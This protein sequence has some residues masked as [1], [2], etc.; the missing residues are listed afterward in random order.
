[1][2]E[3]E[4]MRFVD[5]WTFE[6]SRVFPHPLERVWRAITD[7]N[8]I[9]VWFE[10]N[11]KFDLRLGGAYSFGGEDSTMRGV[12][13]ALDPPRFIRFSDPPSG[14]DSYFQFT[15]E[16]VDGGTRV[17]FTHGGTPGF[18]EGWPPPGLFAGWH[19]ALNNLA[20]LLEA[21]GRRLGPSEAELTALYIVRF[22]EQA[23]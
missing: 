21:I 9:S 15:L 5:R 6:C 2:A 10:E 17:T 22:K 19:K 12:I 3:E 20:D 8:E 4:F 18:I 11:A 1:M 7:P 16:I 14:A 23:R 13:T